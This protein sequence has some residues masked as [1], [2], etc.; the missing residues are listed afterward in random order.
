MKCLLFY[1]C[2]IFC[3]IK[4]LSS[5]TVAPWHPG[6]SSPSDISGIVNPSIA[7]G[8]RGS[9]HETLVTPLAVTIPV[10]VSPINKKI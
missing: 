2:L 4:K 3:K 9:I 5:H 8:S 7:F 10:G 6:S 1:N